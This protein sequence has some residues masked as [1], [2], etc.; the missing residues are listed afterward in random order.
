M[1]KTIIKYT[2]F[3]T[4]WG[5]FGLFSTD[6]VLIRCRLPVK[7]KEKAKFELLGHFLVA[8]GRHN[9]CHKNRLVKIQYEK[10]LFKDL[11]QQI[12]AYFE[13]EYVDFDKGIP[14]NLEGKSEFAR[15]VLRKLQDVKYGRTISYGELAKRVGRPGA[16]RAVGMVMA[17]NPLPLV[18]GC[19]RV[20][21]ADGGLG[22]FSAAG[23]VKLKKKM[24]L[25]ESK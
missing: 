9:H 11:Q 13:G 1:G 22:G 23:G 17:N 14:I 19:H 21:C 6:N 12:T 2:I 5:F 20:I 7:D 8:D 16:A 10:G 15:R 18:I 4:G 24:L 3:R 25:L